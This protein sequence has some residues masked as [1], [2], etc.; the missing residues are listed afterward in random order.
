MKQRIKFLLL[1]YLTAGVGGYLFSQDSTTGMVTT[2]SGLIP[3]TELGITLMHEH[4][5]V[6]FI[7]ADEVSR[8]RYNQ[9]EVFAVA[10][11]HLKRLKALGCQTLVE[12]TPAYLGRD[13]ILLKSLSEASGLNILTNTGYYGAAS[14][15]YVPEFAYEETDQQLAVR[16]IQ[17][18]HQ[19]IEETGIKPGFIKIA[20]DSGPLS[21]IDRKLVRAAA[22]TSRLTGLKIAS[23]TGDGVAVLEELSVLKE[24]GVEADAFIWVHAQSEP[25]TSIHIQV[26]KQGMWIEFDGISEESVDRHVELVMTMIRHNLLSQ[27]LISQDA[28]WYHVGEPEGGEYRGYGILFTQFI[29]ALK[30]A[31]ATET[32]IRML[33]EDNPRKALTIS[34]R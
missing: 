18:V 27:T 28:G 12:C 3:S 29:P 34:K 21:D 24:F 7:G 32:Q 20:V 25:D 1:T 30:A 33:L 8:D 14:D 23:H 4:I 10:L 2:V 15:R 31:G 13:P 11:P 16:W 19:G 9:D 5:L 22:L 6:D 17:E 26:A